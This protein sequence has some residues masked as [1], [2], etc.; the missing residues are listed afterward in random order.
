MPVEQSRATSPAGTLTIMSQS[1]QG[2]DQAA[3]FSQQLQLQG[4]YSPFE[5]FEPHSS[6]PYHHHQQQQQ[7]Q[8]QVIPLQ[9]NPYCS[10]SLAALARPGCGLWESH[11]LPLLLA[12]NSG[13]VK[14]P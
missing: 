1:Y 11:P 4:Y 14:A 10:A 13:R 7:Q 8:Q 2:G 9:D 6:D 3:D 5:Q 12:S